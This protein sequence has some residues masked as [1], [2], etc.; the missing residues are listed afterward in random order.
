MELSARLCLLRYLDAVACLIHLKYLCWKNEYRN[1]H[2]TQKSGRIENN[3]I[4]Y[5]SS[6]FFLNVC[7]IQTIFCFILCF[8]ETYWY[9]WVAFCPSRLSPLLYK[10]FHST[11]R[12]DIFAVLYASQQFLAEPVWVVCAKH[13]VKLKTMSG[14]CILF[15]PG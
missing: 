9:S 5:S 10:S 2:I 14:L 12:K 6:D 11:E 3:D 8:D 7:L 15:I 4:F 1:C 13:L